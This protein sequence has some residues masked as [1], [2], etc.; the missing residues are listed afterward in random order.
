M[1]AREA[2]EERIKCE[3]DYRREE[4]EEGEANKAENK[5]KQ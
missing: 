2:E 4:L 1:I 3:K 5:K